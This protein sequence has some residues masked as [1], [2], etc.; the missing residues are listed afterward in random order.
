M[1]LHHI[2]PLLLVVA[3]GGIL[4]IKAGDKNVEV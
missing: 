1:L 4:F 3:A 2:L